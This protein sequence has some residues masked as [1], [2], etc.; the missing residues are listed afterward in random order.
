MCLVQP[1]KW[2]LQFISVFARIWHHLP[3]WLSA[4]QVNFTPRLMYFAVSLFPLWLPTCEPDEAPK[5]R[6]HNINWINNF[7]I[8]ELTILLVNHQNITGHVTKNVL[9]TAAAEHKSMLNLSI[10]FF[11]YIG[12]TLFCTSQA[13]MWLTARC[14]RW[15]TVTS[16]WWSQTTLKTTL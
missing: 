7:P 14:S 9:P 13:K 2:Q 3:A 8:L 6:M 5:I 11:Q 12:P 16:E 1:K 15:R 10:S 4:Q